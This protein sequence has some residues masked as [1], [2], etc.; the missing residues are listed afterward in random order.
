MAEVGIDIAS[1][2]SNHVDDYLDENFD[3]VWTVCD[4]ARE[5]CPVFPGAV[6]RVHHGFED[7]DRAEPSED[8]LLTVFRRIR[9]EI[10]TC[11]RRLVETK[12]GTGRASPL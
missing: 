1:H 3:L 11:C 8:E 12:L 9:D 4:S 2:T 6:R 5:A 7:P 10:G